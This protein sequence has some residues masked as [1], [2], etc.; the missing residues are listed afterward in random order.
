MHLERRP[1][2]TLQHHHWVAG[3]G[4]AA[5]CAPCVCAPTWSCAPCCWRWGRQYEPR[6][7]QRTAMTSALDWWR[8][9]E[10]PAPSSAATPGRTTRWPPEAAPPAEA[11]R[12]KSEEVKNVQMLS[13]YGLVYF[14]GIWTTRLD[15]TYMALSS[16]FIVP[17]SCLFTHAHTLIHQLIESILFLPRVFK[18]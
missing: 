8:R 14:S 9:G 5:P 10:R 15:D 7:H 4:T 2:T 1:G 13:Y 6:S 17:Q 18:A 3:G 12:V 16:T 11:L